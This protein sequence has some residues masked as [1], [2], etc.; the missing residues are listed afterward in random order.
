MLQRVHKFPPLPFTAFSSVCKMV[1]IFLKSFEREDR[2]RRG[3][4][5]EENMAMQP[6]HILNPLFMKIKCYHFFVITKLSQ[7][8]NTSFQ[9]L[10]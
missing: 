9:N 5:E 10:H 6:Y 2:W 3:G 1:P 8:N 4:K 7:C